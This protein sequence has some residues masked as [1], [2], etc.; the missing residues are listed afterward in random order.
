MKRY[1]PEP[2]EKVLQRFFR[3]HGQERKFNELKVFELWN[4]AVGPEIGKNAQPVSVNNGWLTVKVR[5]SI[6]L[7]E[8]G[9]ERQ[10]LKRKLN[11]LLG[12][13]TITDITFR[14]GPIADPQPEPAPNKSPAKPLSKDLERKFE[15]LVQAV[16]DPQL[17][18][19]L[20]AFLLTIHQNR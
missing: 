14:I 3:Q 16:D 17:R 9:F 5:N 6:W 2:L 4:E 20:K 18:E 1:A 13:G 8:L 15:S 10:K 19:Q 7:Q 12:K 11:R